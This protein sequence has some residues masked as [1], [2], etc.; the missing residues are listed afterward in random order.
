MLS[1]LAAGVIGAASTAIWLRPGATVENTTPVEI[2]TPAAL[3]PEPIVKDLTI[4]RGETLT[5]LLHRA[6][7]KKDAM[8]AMVA[9]IRE[10]FD[11]RKLRAGAEINVAHSALGDFETLEYT[12]DPD[13]KL[14][15]TPG[16]EGF[17]AAIIEIPSIVRTVPVCGTL[18]GSLFES[19]ARMGEKPELAIRMAEIFAWDLDFYRDPQPGDEFCLVIEKKEYL[20]GQPPTYRNILAARYVNS[21][22][23][24]D[25]HMFPDSKGA[26]HYYSRDGRSLQSTFLKS[27]LKFEARISSRFSH[28]RLHPVLNVRR[29]HWGTDYAAP[30]GTPVHAIAAGR[31]AF[32]GYS[33]GAGNLIKI[34]H[35][36]GYESQYLHLSRRLVR[37]GQRVEQ[38]QQ[39]GQVGATGLATGPHLDLRLSKNGKFLDFERLKPTREATI[40]ADQKEAFA[41]ARDYY[42]S[43]LES[44]PDAG[45][46]VAT[47]EPSPQE[48]SSAEGL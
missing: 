44:G 5:Q 33:G 24:Y 46:A 47:R 26:P 32:S 29:P 34:S 14:Q 30:V 20:N 16:D 17:R 31:V 18:Q 27:P 42:L 15:V 3:A 6:G 25:A 41:A 9:A 19:V 37:V 21:G 2:E 7:I 36:N 1:I 48:H 35:T 12:L 11:V 28:A 4:Q 10:V 23:A 43:L 45:T 39:I 22:T 38:G 8:L 40:P 13:R